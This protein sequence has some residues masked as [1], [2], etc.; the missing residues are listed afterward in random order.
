[1]RY[2]LAARSVTYSYSLLQAS[3]AFRE[4]M[5]RLDSHRREQGESLSRAQTSRRGTALLMSA[6]QQRVSEAEP[7]AAGDADDDPWAEILL[8]ERD[9]A[10]ARGGGGGG[11]GGDDGDAEGSNGDLVSEHG[12]ERY[13]LGIID[14]LQAYNTRKARRRRARR[15]PV[16][17]PRAPE[18]PGPARGYTI[19][20][21]R[22]TS[23]R[24]SR[25]RSR[26]RT[27]SP[28]RACPPTCTPRAS[29]SISRREPPPARGHHPLLS[30]RAA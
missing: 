12:D 25:S 7:A 23:Q 8:E 9:E 1:M 29:A 24:R 30:P 4:P 21:W 18:Q 13:F 19:R 28:C 22:S 14:I 3:A 15:A 5:L 26:A 2:A 10:A 11:G 20:R 6:I 27:S 16:P 17:Q